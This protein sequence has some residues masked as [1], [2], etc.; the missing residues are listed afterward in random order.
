MPWTT[1]DYLL[2]IFELVVFSSYNH[3]QACWYLAALFY[4]QKKMWGFPLTY[5]WERCWFKQ[6]LRRSSLYEG[7]QWLSL[8][9]NSNFSYWVSQKDVLT[10]TII[11]TMEWRMSKLVQI[12]MVSLCDTDCEFYN[13]IEILLKILVAM[14]CFKS[15]FLKRKIV[16]T[17]FSANFH[18]AWHSYIT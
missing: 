4:S 1:E 3:S 11:P 10:S 16:L 18:I 12:R 8:T 9:R 13:S 2:E 6:H 5:S 7:N 15:K 17:I 14:C